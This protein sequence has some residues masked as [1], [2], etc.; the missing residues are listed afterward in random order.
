M[1]GKNHYVEV[2]E[3]ALL[4]IQ[5][6]NKFKSVGFK[7]IMVN[8]LIEK[9]SVNMELDSEDAIFILLKSKKST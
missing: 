4:M 8:M 1:K 7:S 5:L 6:N 2:G 3:N 9:V